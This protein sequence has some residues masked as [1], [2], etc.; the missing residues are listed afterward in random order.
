VCCLPHRH[1][2]GPSTI[3]SLGRWSW[4]S[5]ISCD[6]SASTDTGSSVLEPIRGQG[7]GRQPSLEGWTINP[8][9]APLGLRSSPS[10]STTPGLGKSE[11]PPVP[12]FISQ[13]AAPCVRRGRGGGDWFAS[14]PP[15]NSK[16]APRQSVA[17]SPS[18]FGEEGGWIAAIRPPASMVPPTVHT[19]VFWAAPPLSFF[20]TTC[21]NRRGRR[22]HT[23]TGVAK[24][25]LND[26]Q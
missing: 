22:H 3:S 20:L 4:T 23:E 10:W 14:R 17:D 19:R 9:V 6:G 25:T 21:G 7:G 13:A 5:T 15:P 12:S 26:A 1:G 11:L 2:F 16:L 18:V 8:G 24:V